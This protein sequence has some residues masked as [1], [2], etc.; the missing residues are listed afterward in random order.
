M[1]SREVIKGLA[2]LVPNSSKAIDAHKKFAAYKKAADEYSTF[3]QNVLN[4]IHGKWQSDEDMSMEQ[5]LEELPTW[6]HKFVFAMAKLNY[7][8]ENGGFSQWIDN[9]YA[10]G[11]QGDLLWSELPKDPKNFPILSKIRSLILSVADELQGLDGDFNSFDQAE[12]ILDESRS[13]DFVRQK[14]IEEN[15][16]SIDT[17]E[18]FFDGDFEN[19]LEVDLAEYGLGDETVT[20]DD[21]SVCD[22]ISDKIENYLDLEGDLQE[23]DREK[24]DSLT[25]LQDMVGRVGEL[26]S[27]LDS[28]T[29]KYEAPFDKLDS[30][31]YKITEDSEALWKEVAHYA[32]SYDPSMDYLKKS[33]KIGTFVRSFGHRPFT[34]TAAINLGNNFKVEAK[35]ANGLTRILSKQQLTTIAKNTFS[36]NKA[37][38]MTTHKAYNADFDLYVKE[39]IRMAGLP[40]DEDMNWSSYLEKAYKSISNDPEVRDEAAHHQIII[41]LYH[42][43]TLKKFDPSKSPAPNEPLAKQVTI[44]LKQ[45]FSHSVSKAR[46]WVRKN[47]G[48]GK[49]IKDESGETR[50]FGRE[51]QPDYIDESGESR[52]IFDTQDFGVTDD[53]SEMEGQEDIEEFKKEFE[54]FLKKRFGKIVSPNMIVLFDLLLNN[55]EDDKRDLYTKFN[56]ITDKSESYFKKAIIN[57]RSA[58]SEFAESS[59]ISPSNKIIKLINAYKS[60]LLNIQEEEVPMSKEKS[61]RL[62]ALLESKRK[63]AKKASKASKFATLRRIAEEEPEAVGEAIAELRDTFMEQVE[64]LDALAEN[65]GVDVETAEEDAQADLEFQASKKRASKPTPK[66]GALLKK[67]AEE[68]P[69]QVELALGEIYGNIDTLAEGVE[70]LAENLGVELPESPAEEQ[71]ELEEGMESHDF[72]EMPE[73]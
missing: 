44:Y 46:D 40:V 61:S 13:E 22:E 42:L 4:E 16:G 53:M 48:Y 56:E 62:A 15:E 12:E 70:N 39:A 32:E 5:L 34:V 66:F 71:E 35:Y 36:F 72:D 23:T 52:S 45:M 64:A 73:A 20:L 38:N 63:E 65:L 49:Q 59:E 31:Y 6:A 3:I 27:E 1:T 28:F 47:F 69:E 14:F 26:L 60:E 11:G 8:V 19:G 67:L 41:H 68:D 17:L 21:E 2:D 25:E 24:Y 37:A 43:E 18:R 7:Q 30:M 58:M 29:N 50:E 55:S 9:G 54:P 57:L 10:G 33:F 51:V